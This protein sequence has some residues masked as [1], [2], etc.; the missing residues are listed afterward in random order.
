LVEA[1]NQSRSISRKVRVTAYDLLV[2]TN[3]HTGGKNYERLKQA[4]R[5]WPERGSKQTSPLMANAS[6]RASA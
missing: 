5:G 2:T 4:L 6:A 1:L 3:R